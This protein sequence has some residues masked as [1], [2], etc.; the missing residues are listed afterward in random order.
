MCYCL[1]VPVIVT[2]AG[3]V[4]GVQGSRA[5]LDCSATG[6]PQPAVTWLLNS[7]PVDLSDPRIKQAANGSLILSPVR[8]MDRGDYVCQASNPAGTDTIT[9]TLVV[10]G[11]TKYG[12]SL[13]FQFWIF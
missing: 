13:N 5:V 12:V 7:V 10:Y 3:N 9:T 4:T 1:G 8:T 2:A 11:N 6:D